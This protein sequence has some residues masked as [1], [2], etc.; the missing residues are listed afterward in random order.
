MASIETLV[1]APFLLLS[2]SLWV[3]LLRGAL[4]KQL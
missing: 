1:Y 3:Y 4:G 2:G